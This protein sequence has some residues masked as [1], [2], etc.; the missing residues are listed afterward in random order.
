MMDDLIN[1]DQDYID[2]YLK[3]LSLSSQEDSL[4]YLT[5][6]CNFCNKHVKQIHMIPSFF[7]RPNRGLCIKGVK[8]CKDCINKGILCNLGNL[9]N[10]CASPEELYF[11]KISIIKRS[12]GKYSLTYINGF[13][14][15]DN[16]LL[17]SCKFI[18]DLMFDDLDYAK[19]A[20]NNELNDMILN[21]FPY[22]QKHFPNKNN[23]NNIITSLDF[24]IDTLGNNYLTYKICDTEHIYISSMTELVNSKYLKITH[25]LLRTSIIKYCNDKNIIIHEY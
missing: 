14:L 5:L 15:E 25:P 18:P 8:Y 19:K 9:Y 11:N 20:L 3:E 2:L 4:L 21:T 12:N 23:I 1:N 10:S 13:I 24:Y 7:E 22:I 6:Y 17:L 16:K